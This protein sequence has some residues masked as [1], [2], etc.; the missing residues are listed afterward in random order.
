M[1]KSPPT[2]RLAV[3][4]SS[5]AGRCLKRGSRPSSL[6]AIPP[7]ASTSP[8]P[9]RN[10]VAHDAR[11]GAPSVWSQTGHSLAGRSGRYWPLPSGDPR[12]HGQLASSSVREEPGA[13]TA[14]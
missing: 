5:W 4:G 3:L 2:I 8:P 13:R 14:N 12:E 10:D 7:V 9:F 6:P 11:L 1:G